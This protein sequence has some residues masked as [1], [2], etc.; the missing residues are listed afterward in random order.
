[1]AK[2]RLDAKGLKEIKQQIADHIESA[3]CP[4]LSIYGDLIIEIKYDEEK[5]AMSI[6]SRARCMPEFGGDSIPKRPLKRLEEKGDDK[7]DP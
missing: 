3:V 5:G 2:K 6:E 4:R 7:K 1:M